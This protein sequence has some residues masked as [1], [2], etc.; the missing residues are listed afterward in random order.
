[1]ESVFSIFSKGILAVAAALLA[2]ALAPYSE[3]QPMSAT[4]SA[5][6]FA[7]I[8]GV[9]Q[10]ALLTFVDKQLP[11]LYSAVCLL[12]GMV[13]VGLYWITSTNIAKKLHHAF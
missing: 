6:L 2:G 11:G 5:F 4:V 13:L 10:L 8:Y 9:C 7:V 3:E 1:M 12:L